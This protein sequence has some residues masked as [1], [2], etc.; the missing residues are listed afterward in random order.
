MAF[1]IGRGTFEEGS[2]WTNM[3]P[4]FSDRGSNI[5]R[6]LRIERYTASFSLG[7]GLFVAQFLL[8]CAG[9]IYAIEN[10]FALNTRLVNPLY[11]VLRYIELRWERLPGMDGRGEFHGAIMLSVT[12]ALVSFTILTLHLALIFATLKLVSTLLVRK[13]IIP[14]RS[15]DLLTHLV[16]L[17]VMSQYGAGQYSFSHQLILEYFRGISPSATGDGPTSRC[18]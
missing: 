4:A 16:Q 17:S 10:G 8:F 14:R 13:E 5:S 15:T 2:H 7:L 18:L 11:G 12:V 3:Q 1:I 9:V 6:F